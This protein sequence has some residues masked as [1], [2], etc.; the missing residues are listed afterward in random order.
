[1]L[2]LLTVIILGITQGLTEFLPVSSSG[3]LVIFQT[4]LPNFKQPGVLFDVV[5]HLGTTMAV[6]YYYRKDIYIYTLNNFKVI[7]IGTIPAVVVGFLFSD[8]LEGLFESTKAVG[9]ALLITS[10]FNVLTDRFNKNEN[11]TNKK[12][13]IVGC[14]QG[15]AIVPG[16]SRSG[17]TIFAGRWQGM[18]SE[19]AIKFSFILS[20]PAIL[21]ASFLQIVKYGFSNQISFVNYSVGFASA[22]LGGYFAIIFLIQLTKN[23]KYK[24]FALYTFILAIMA[25]VFI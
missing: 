22:F 10:V 20:I 3:H 13:F 12:S 24:Y 8:F 16:I 11:N 4:L 6:I 21:G 19:K 18:S 7:V 25:I 1:M 17:S 15:F 5:L 14:F 23:S 2:N 9:F